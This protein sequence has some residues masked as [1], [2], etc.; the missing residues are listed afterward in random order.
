MAQKLMEPYYFQDQGA[1]R[2]LSFQVTAGMVDHRTGA[3]VLKFHARLE[4]LSK[5]LGGS[6][7]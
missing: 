5:A 7:R 3:D 4:Q 6:P 1:P 2:T